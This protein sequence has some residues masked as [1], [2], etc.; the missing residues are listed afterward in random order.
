[1]VQVSYP[2]VYIVEVPSGVRAIVGVSTSIAA[3]FGR[4]A[5]GPINRAV[6]I[7]DRSSFLRQFGGPHPASDLAA[8][9]DQFFNNGGTDCYIV[10]IAHNPDTADLVVRSLTN[11]SVLRA[12]ARDAGAWG[13][14]LRLEINYNTANSEDTFNLRALQ[15][16]PQRDLVRFRARAAEQAH[17]EPFG[18]QLRQPPGELDPYR[19]QIVTRAAALAETAG[20]ALVRNLSAITGGTFGFL[21]GFFVLLYAMFFFLIGGRA[22]LDRVLSYIP[23]P[24]ADKERLAGRFLSVARATLKGTLVV[25]LVQAVLTGLALWIAGIGAAAFWAT[26]VFVLSV[27][28]GIGAPIVWVPAVI[29]LAAT[30]RIGAA[31]AL[32][33]WCAAVVGTIDNL[34][35][36]RLVGEDTQMPDLLILVSTLGGITLFGAAGLIVGPIVAALFI[37]VWE[38]YGTAFHDVLATSP[39]GAGDGGSGTS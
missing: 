10:R 12:S 30:G 27:L 20:N 1:M 22:T 15:I 34:L 37:T 28:P 21:L 3:F 33:A 13:N 7:T 38:I 19:E 17:V 9:V 36:P 5:K 4:T 29:Y 35:R 16:E 24:S 11:V 8:G 23:L 2:G 6:R 32:A 26:I 31:I 18:A 14:N 25:G 39:G